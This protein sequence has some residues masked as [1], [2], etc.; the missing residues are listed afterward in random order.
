MRLQADALTIEII[1]E[2]FR[3]DPSSA[4][5][6]RTY[7]RA[8]RL[9]DPQSS[10]HGVK[11]YADEHLIASAVLIAGGGASGVHERT[12]L[13]APSVIYVAVGDHV[14]CLSLPTL[15]LAWATQTDW[16][17]CFGVHA[18][19]GSTDVLSHGEV[20]IARVNNSGRILW[21]TS[22]KDIFTGEI[23][24]DDQTVKAVD[25][26]GE[27]YVFDLLTGKPLTGQQFA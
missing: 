13:V 14:V 12:V 27:S 16:A 26:E 7:E 8:Y 19:P 18:I 9:G 3:Y 4:D 24:I 20:E 25:F 2:D 1:P 21:S 17:T 6:I 5:N 11:V 23:A 22:G 15:E 10:V